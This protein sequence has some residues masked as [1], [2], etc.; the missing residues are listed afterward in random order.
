MTIASERNEL[1]DQHKGIA[2]SSAIAQISNVIR[3]RHLLPLFS[4]TN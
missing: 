3:V 2:D 4:T 1:L